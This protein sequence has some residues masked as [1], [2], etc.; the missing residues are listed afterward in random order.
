MIGGRTNQAVIADPRSSIYSNFHTLPDAEEEESGLHDTHLDYDYSEHPPSQAPRKPHLVSSSYGTRLGSNVSDASSHS[1]QAASIAS[2]APAP[3]LKNEPQQHIS[4]LDDQGRAMKPFQALAEGVKKSS[5]QLPHL[6]APPK[7]EIMPEAKEVATGSSLPPHLRTPIRDAPVPEAKE[8]ATSGSL[9][10]HMRGSLSNKTI[11]KAKE[12]PTSATSPTHMRA[13][14]RRT[15]KSESKKV[16]SSATL[17]LH[18]RAPSS[19]E[20]LQGSK[21]RLFS[22]I[23]SSVMHRGNLKTL[24]D[25]TFDVVSGATA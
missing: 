15:T 18:M 25:G 20:S 23:S 5:K 16:A 11:P 19:I 1:R 2:C 14:I 13:S 17:P 4:R 12:V 22:S 9:P 7:K 10:P 6:R 3:S 24:T 8:V 21:V